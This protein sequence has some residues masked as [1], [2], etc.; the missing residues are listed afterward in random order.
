[1]RLAP[2]VLDADDQHVLGEPSL[3]ARLPARDPER[4]ALLAQ[5]RIAAVARAEALD[6]ERLGKMHD[7]PAIRVEL[8]DRVQALHEVAFARDAPQGSVAHSRH[9]L[10]VGCDISAVGDLDAAARV[11]R[12]EGTH[13]VRD[14]V[15]RAPAHAALE[16]R[17]ELAS[18][19]GRR[20]PV[21]VRARVFLPF[22]T[23]EGQVLDARDVRGIRAVQVTAG[24]T[25]GIELQEIAR[26]QHLADQLA[27]LPVGTVAPVDLVGT[28]TRGDFENPVPEAFG[29]MLGRGRTVGSGSHQDP[30]E[31]DPE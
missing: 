31:F 15:H 5:E 23:D 27:V 30:I 25:V 10:H 26:A 4:M 24:K 17:V 21:V 7:E 20:H 28:G 18:R 12:V 3:V 29:C 6:L 11:G 13:A 8:P 19:L 1:V 9:E 2:R 22:R 14:H 16:K